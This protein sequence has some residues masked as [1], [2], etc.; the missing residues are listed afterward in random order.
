MA[1]VMMVATTPTSKVLD[2]LVPHSGG[3]R[4]RETVACPSSIPPADVQE[5]I[6]YG[7]QHAM[8]GSG[9]RTGFWVGSRF[10]TAVA[11]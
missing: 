5:I 8:R 4:S 6:D 7:A 3:T 1:G 9:A 2:A 11:D 10:V